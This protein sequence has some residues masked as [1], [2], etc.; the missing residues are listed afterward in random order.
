MNMRSLMAGMIAAGLATG[1]ANA[2]LAGPVEIGVSTNPNSYGVAEILVDG[3]SADGVYREV[4][5]KTL[6]YIVSVRGDRPKKATGDGD[7]EIQFKKESPLAPSAWGSYVIVHGDVTKIWKHYKVSIPYVDPWSRTIVNERI[8]PIEVCN[9]NLAIRKKHANRRQEYEEMLSKG[10]SM[11]HHDAYRIRGYVHYPMKG[12]ALLGNDVKDYDDVEAVP[13]KITCMA[14]GRPRPSKDTST[15]G[16]PGPKGKPLPPTVSNATL[17]IEPAKVV[18]DGKF[19]CPS[20][21]KLYGHVEVIRKFYGKALFV[22]PH[23]LSAITTLNFQSEGSRN[24]TATYDMDWHKMSGFTTQ[25]NA[26]PKKQK[27]TFHFNVADKDGKL[28]KSVEETV[29]VS[30]K[31]IKVAVPTVGEEKAVAPAN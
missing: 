27:L 15:T 8:S 14:L 16:A 2:A 10:L 12:S 9:D 23:Y 20:Q 28:R 22:G 5:N 1:I 19:L 24:V 31:K 17:R 25:P 6:D 7:L 3:P 30:C 29:E 21:L 26:A 13:V 11:I 4:R 18:Q